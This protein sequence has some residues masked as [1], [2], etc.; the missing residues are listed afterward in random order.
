L[1]YAINGFVLEKPPYPYPPRP[2]AE[3][4]CTENIKTDYVFPNSSSIL[5][6]EMCAVTYNMPVPVL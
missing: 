4:F 3:I 1:K 5:L 2:P 6:D